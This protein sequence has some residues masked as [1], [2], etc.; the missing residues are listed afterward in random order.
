MG[1]AATA[2]AHAAEF[3]NGDFARQNTA[4]AAQ[5]MAGAARGRYWQAEFWMGVAYEVGRGVTH[6]RQ[7]ALAM[8]DRAAADG[9]AG[10]PQMIAAYLRGG[11]A[12]KRFKDAD[13]LNAAF[14]ADFHDQYNSHYYPSGGNLAVPGSRAWWDRITGNSTGCYFGGPGC[15]KR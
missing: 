1:A 5:L 14:N 10:M 9:Q 6:N 8:L 15:P 3:D 7:T 4:K 13:D 11:G 12:N 2:D